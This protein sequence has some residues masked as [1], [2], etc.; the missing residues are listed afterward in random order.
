MTGE[1]LVSCRCDDAGGLET[2]VTTD[3]TAPSSGVS[4]PPVSSAGETQ[5]DRY[6]TK[7]TR[8]SVSCHVC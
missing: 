4:E 1:E 8:D 2:G 3:E 5:L 6:V 7:L